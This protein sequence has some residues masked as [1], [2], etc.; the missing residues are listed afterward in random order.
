LVLAFSTLLVFWAP[1]YASP[2]LA[3]KPRLLFTSSSM[4]D[5]S[6]QLPFFSGPTLPST[7][8]SILI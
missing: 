8:T 5:F 7:Q 2:D 6:A 1:C 3:A 4:D